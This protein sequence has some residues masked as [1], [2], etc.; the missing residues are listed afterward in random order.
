MLR[1]N[2]MHSCMF[3]V[4][5]ICMTFAEGDISCNT[6]ISCQVGTYEATKILEDYTMIHIYAFVL[7]ISQCNYKRFQI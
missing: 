4:M 6:V 3:Q 1:I 2:G 5:K 7:Y